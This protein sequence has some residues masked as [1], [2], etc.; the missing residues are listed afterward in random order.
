VTAADPDGQAIT[1]FAATGL[2]SGA[3]FTKSSNQ[4][5]TFTWT[6]TTAQVSATPYH[7]TFTATNARSGSAS[8]DIM[9]SS[10]PPPSSELVA[11]GGFETN[12]AGWGVYSSAT[13]TQASEGHTGVHALQIRGSSSAP[14]GCDDTPNAVTQVRAKG[15]IY[16]VSAWVK[17]STGSRGSAKIRIYE[18][19][20]ST[21]QGT[22]AYSQVL[23]L[24]SVWQHLTLDY[25]VR[26]AGTT[27]SLRVTDAPVASGE[28]FLVDDL[29]IVLLSSPVAT[30][31]A[32]SE[33]GPVDDRT[34]V[35]LR[36]EATFAPNPAVHSG[37]LTF[38]TTRPG[39][40]L[41]TLFDAGG[42]RVHTLLEEGTLSAGTHSL[43]LE[44]RANG[45]P[46]PTG[47]YYYRIQAAE[48]ALSGRF[49]WMR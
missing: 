42:R 23:P 2:P 40:V 5:G 36:F 30:P 49:V 8:T 37:T 45:I 11:N 20:G 22:T 38:S 41:V 13:L 34:G 24:T 44:G 1:T 7:V 16:R 46:L 18:F 4:L 3:L 39:G 15:A 48:G 27:L 17:S 35:P 9:V 19:L 12:L 26:T 28:T 25:T 47:I 14:F 33:P 21:Q 31:I 10:A 43:R 6:P 32:R 29:S